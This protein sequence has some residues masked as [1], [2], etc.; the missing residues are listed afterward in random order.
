MFRFIILAM[1]SW[2]AVIHADSVRVFVP[3][4]SDSMDTIVPINRIDYGSFVLLEVTPAQASRLDAAPIDTR[5]MNHLLIDAHPFNTQTDT[6]QATADLP[7][8]SASLEGLHLIQFAGPIKQEWLDTVKSTG[9]RLIHYVASNGYLVWANAAQRSM[10]E[11]MVGDSAM[12]QFSAPYHSF[13]KVGPQLRELLSDKNDRSATV[14]VYLQL[15][16]HDGVDQSRALIDQMAISQDTQWSELLNFH[17]IRITVNKADILTLAQMTDLYTI[18]R[19]FERELMD[20]VQNQVLTGVLRPD[21]SGPV[22]PGYL[23]FLT[24]LGFP[25]TPSAYPIVDVVDDGIGNGTTASND[26][27]FHEAGLL[28]NPTRLA[29]VGNCTDS[30][31]AESL[32]GHG[33]LNLNIVGGF[34]DRIGFPYVDPNTYIRTQGVNPYGR[35]A[36][37]RI[38]DPG[39]D[40][41]SCGGTDTGTIQSTQDNG[42][43]ISSNSW[44]C[45]GC[46]G[47]YDDGS[48]AYDVGV[49]DA[50][51]TEPGNQEL[52]VTFSAGNS[53]PSSATVGTPGNGKNMI[54]VGASENDRPTDEDGN[55]TDGCNIGPTGADD[56]MDV[57]GFSSRGPSPGNRNKPEIIAPGTHIH[58]T[59]STS[60]SF[61]GSS[62]CDQFRPSGQTVISAS[63]GTSHSNPAVAGV[64][65]LVYY[66]I[67]ND[68]G[69]ILRESGTRGGVAPSPAMMKSYL[70]AHPTYL[71]GVGANDDFP[72]NS[73]GYGM[74]NMTLLFDETPKFILDQTVL[75]D[76]TG[77][78]Y[79]FIGAAADPSKPVRIALAYTD[80][81]GA[82]GTSPQVNNLDLRVE[83]AGNTY[84]GNNFTGEFSD[85]G[86]TA[87]AVNN[88]EGVFL[89][90]GTADALTITV[91]ALNIAGDGVPNSG[92]ATDQDFA[93][94]CYN[95]VQEPTFTL[96]AM[97]SQI[98]LCQPDDAVYDLSISSILG[99]TTDVTL[100]TTGDPAGS[101]IVF[102]TNPVTPTDPATAL[103][104]TVGNT[105]GVA[106]GSYPITITG[107]AG[108][109]IKNR[110]VTLDLFAVNPDAPVL[111]SPADQATLVDLQPVLEWT[112]LANA[113]SYLVEV[114]TT[115]DFANIIFSGS[116]DAPTNST[117]PGMPLPSNVE[118]FW[119][120]TATNPCGE[121]TSTTS[122]F[123]TLPLPG[124]CPIGVD[125]LDIE[126]FDFEAGDNG[127]TSAS[128]VGTNTWTLSTANP[129]TDVAS[130]QHWHVDDQ[131]T[132]SDTHL[133]S[134]VISL[135]V[136]NSPLTFQFH[137]NQQLESRTSGGCWDGGILEVSV[138]GGAFTQIDNSQLATDPYD[139]EINAGPLDGSQAWCGDPQAYLNS[140]VAIDN[141]AGSDV[142]FR[143]RLSTD[144]S[145][146]RPGWDIDD[147]LIQGCGISST[148]FSDGF[149]N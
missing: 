141:L 75:F 36:G 109:E 39:F 147:V 71:S 96:S 64:A 42:G 11:Q 136:G 134:P 54:T 121:M 52:I 31:T 4:S 139:G 38:F 19:T 66:W 97:P 125:T 65:S 148:I 33:H 137:N 23:D 127:W 3:K 37:T 112:A 144:G 5:L 74:P 85:I 132:T 1:L 145:V 15:A 138:D 83:T 86:G 102:S 95:C 9:A 55:W 8:M 88:Y 50:D 12:L 91:S 130:V 107:T 17:S 124:D 25:T 105:A 53:G 68:R 28:S 27:T 106:A 30:A 93:L 70:M 114:S 120:V 100:T 7:L 94:V 61:N 146:G 29:Y 73:Q 113:V 98:G 129:T 122:S 63:S 22:A 103:T 47:S 32:G 149:E 135:P 18:N 117:I 41:S 99:F 49:R 115:D 21:N 89:T 56:V 2:S 142:Q 133:T 26:P 60:A 20:E 111:I 69:N 72:S 131:S 16:D 118:L 35:L 44:G 77:D 104:M 123:T 67:Q 78:E 10:L 101:S 92:D 45:S 140:I 46:A 143:F 79:V 57:I 84:L 6:L 13:F 128:T 90:A 126:L 43:Q 34:E 87:D 59:A 119:R 24:A 40:L 116:V 80:Q 58:G 48:Q 110:D 14:Q 51:L 82:V 62:V 108:T 76:D 81:A